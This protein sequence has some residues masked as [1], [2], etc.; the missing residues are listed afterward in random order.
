[1]FHAHVMDLRARGRPRCVFLLCVRA[2]GEATFSLRAPVPL[3]QA[4]NVTPQAARMC[5]REPRE[6][7]TRSH[8]GMHTS[9][10]P[11]S[12]GRKSCNQM[13]IGGVNQSNRHYVH[14]P[15]RVGRQQPAD[16][17]ALSEAGDTDHSPPP[18]PP[19]ARATNT[20]RQREQETEGSRG[21][22]L[23]ATA[24]GSSIT[25]S[26]Q[27]R[28]ESRGQLLHGTHIHT[29]TVLHMWL[30]LVPQAHL[31]RRTWHCSAWRIGAGNVQ[32]N[33]ATHHPL[34][35][36]ITYQTHVSSLG[37]ARRC[38][39]ANLG[40]TPQSNL[41]P[42][43]LPVH[44][45]TL[46]PKPGTGNRGHRPVRNVRTRPSQARA[47]IGWKAPRKSASR[48]P[49]LQSVRTSSAL[50]AAPPSSARSCSS[51]HHPPPPRGQ[52]ASMA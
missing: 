37:N 46:R 45:C 51:A 21:G 39:G 38:A 47:P 4:R 30:I 16:A 40:R 29:P 5:G 1:M 20:V 42:T 25:S 24:R 52:H 8:P 10:A 50:P 6:R 7:T 36:R 3:R 15:G 44:L 33:V 19:S 14:P 17:A 12:N 18:P 26:T 2:V 13:G 11:H 49:A 34:P 9:Q 41:G 22:Y 23:E 35:T 31:S 48:A 27:S 43:R 28:E 32:P